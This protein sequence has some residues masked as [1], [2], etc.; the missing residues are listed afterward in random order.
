MLA[1]INLFECKEWLTVLCFFLIF[2]QKVG[3]RKINFKPN[4]TGVTGQLDGQH[5]RT[6][7]KCIQKTSHSSQV[8]TFL[9]AYASLNAQSPRRRSL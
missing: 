5:H 9:T 3:L 4:L 8:H 6:H 2:L 1:K 7:S